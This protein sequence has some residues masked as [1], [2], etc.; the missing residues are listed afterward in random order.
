[1]IETLAEK[2][3]YLKIGRPHNVCESCGTAI[4]HAGKHPSV[5]RRAAPPAKGQTD[6]D[7]P[8]REDYCAECW[9]QL[10]E[11]DFV[12]FWVTRREAPKTRKIEGRKERNAALVAWFEHLRLQ[13]PDDETLQSTFFLAHLLMKYGVFKWLRTRSEED[14]SETIIFRQQGSDDEIEIVAMDFS[15][16]RSVEIKRELDEFFVQYANAQTV[17]VANEGTTQN[18]S[19][20]ED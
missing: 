20:S 1:M 14:G 10:A 11:R 15:D 3:L 6:S 13:K 9:Q 4:A 2:D 18:T 5:L 7:G 12:G 8:K 19:D 16:E 17:E